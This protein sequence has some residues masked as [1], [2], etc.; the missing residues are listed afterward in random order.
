MPQSFLSPMS[1]MI[2]TAGATASNRIANFRDA[3]CLGI[4]N[5]SATFTGT[6]KIQVAPVSGGTMSDLTSAGADVT[7][8]AG[9]CI[10]ITDIAFEQIRL[11]SSSAEGAKRTFTVMKRWE[12]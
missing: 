3:R 2:V 6:V 1:S 8:A 4:F 10:V 7:I 9:D 5:G 11:L 12:S